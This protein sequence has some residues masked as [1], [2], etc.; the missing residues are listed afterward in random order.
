MDATSTIADKVVDISYE[1][2]PADTREITKRCILDTLGVIIAGSTAEQACKEVVGM[3]KEMGGKP[4]STIIAYGGKVPALMAAFA[5]GS[6]SHAVDYDDVHDSANCHPSANTIPAAMA[7]AERVGGV[8]GKQFITAVTMG[9]DVACRLGSALPKLPG[10]YD[11]FLPPILGTF[12]STAAA[13]KLLGLSKD[14]MV[15]A[16]SI[17]I[18]QAAGSRAMAKDVKSVIRAI[19]DSFPARNGVLSALMAQRDIIGGSDSLDGKL[20]LFDLYFNGEYKSANL[21]AEL[22]KKFFVNTV[23]FKPWPSC[24]LT[25]AYISAILELAQEYDIKPDNVKEI[26]AVI[27]NNAIDLCEPLEERRKP[28][29]GIHAKLNIP[30]TLAVALARRKVVLGDFLPESLKDPAILQIASRVNYRLHHDPDISG[31]MSAEVEIKRND[32]RQYTKKVQFAYGHPRNPMSKD[33]LITKFRDCARYSARP[34]AENRID[35][36]I[37]LVNNLENLAD[38][39]QVIELLG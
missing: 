15:S 36:V 8:S 14:Q 22:G 12:S 20:G 16:F 37:D 3:V 39:S 26:T 32:G 35:K 13:G 19:R 11:F 38:V 29:L 24:R 6:M 17:A 23:S 33:D 18:H 31:D 10:E 34:L 1:D 2:L 5:N 21:T 7:I 9:I 30:F 28:Q 27:S 4:E 25:H